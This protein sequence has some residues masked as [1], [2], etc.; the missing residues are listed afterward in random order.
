MEKSKK[1]NILNQVVMSDIIKEI[2]AGERKALAG[3]LSNGLTL[4]D[5]GSLHIA[6]TANHIDIIKNFLMVATIIDGNALASVSNNEFKKVINIALT[7]CFKL[8]TK[9]RDKTNGLNSFIIELANVGLVAFTKAFV[10]ALCYS[11]A[12]AIVEYDGNIRLVS[13]DTFNKVKMEAHQKMWADI[14]AQ[15]GLND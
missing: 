3:I 4:K 12:L 10:K 2:D 9:Q 1:V 8:K 7:E 5:D 11:N 13:I 14:K 6:L 15:I